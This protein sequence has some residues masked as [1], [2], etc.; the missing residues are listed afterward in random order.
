[1]TA[2]SAA[3]ASRVALAKVVW[4]AKADAVEAE[5]M[6]KRAL[7]ACPYDLGALMLYAELLEE[8]YQDFDGAERLY[9]TALSN[10][11]A[12]QPRTGVFCRWV[13]LNCRPH[14]PARLLAP[15]SMAACTL[16]Q[17]AIR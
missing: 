10:Q 9:Q 3:A 5:D 6:L 11:A 4:K 8:E 15:C 7:A 16:Q 2:T 12:G 1:M 17:C 13:S 14:G